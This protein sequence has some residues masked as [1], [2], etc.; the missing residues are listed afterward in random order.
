MAGPF[1]VA[2]VRHTQ[3]N[4]ICVDTVAGEV[5]CLETRADGASHYIVSFPK[6]CQKEATATVT[7]PE[8]WG[9]TGGALIDG[10]IKFGCSAGIFHLGDWCT[11]DALRTYSGAVR[12]EKTF[13]MGQTLP[14]T[15]VLDLGEVVSSARVSI[16]GH[17]AGIRLAPPYRFDI[18]P[19]LQ[20]GVNKVEIR[21]T[22][23]SSNFFLT[24]PTTYGGSTI[25]GII[26]PVRIL[27]P[28]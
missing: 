12:Y 19:W 6:V 11:N 13:E 15:A 14:E 7:V 28:L 8:I 18:A 27:Y 9:Y 10:P 24:T 26:G 3:R 16:N 1:L 23:T 17:E 2:G 20:S 4:S 22:N 25:S 21:V 5:L